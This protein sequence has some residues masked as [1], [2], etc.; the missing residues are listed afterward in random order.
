[1]SSLK[2][3]AFQDFQRHSVPVHMLAEYWYCAAQIPNRKL[4]GDIE[5]PTLLEGRG[6]HETEAQNILAKLGR[7]RRVKARTVFDIMLLS[8]ENIRRA[9]A[10]KKVL[11]N[12]EGKVL[13]ATILPELGIL[14]KPDRVDCS[15]GVNPV[16]IETKTKDVFPRRIWPDHEL[17]VA[18]Y[19]LGLE[20]LSFHPTRGMLEY[21]LR[22]DPSSKMS[23]MIFLKDHLR[24][25]VISTAKTVVNL[26]LEKEEPMPTKNPRKCVKCRFNESCR[27]KQTDGANLRED[28]QRAL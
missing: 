26:L 3:V 10:R 25:R 20:R 11:A 19:M 21:V 5:T 13:F 12:A 22:S 2:K 8:Y 14:G 18:T 27:W 9:L 15:D 28:L 23:H 4:Q 17:Q 7:L 6:I 1:M 16:I 24:E